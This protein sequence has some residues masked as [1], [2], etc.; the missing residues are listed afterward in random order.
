MQT[1]IR[2]SALVLAAVMSLGVVAGLIALRPPLTQMYY[3]QMA[4]LIAGA[5]L[6]VTL[7]NYVLTA[8]LRRRSASSEHTEEAPTHAAATVDCTPTAASPAYAATEESELPTAPIAQPAGAVVRDEVLHAEEML[9]DGLDELLDM[10]YEAAADDPI[11]AIAAYRRALLRYPD[12]SYMPYLII[13]LSTLYKR[14]GDYDAALALYD[15]ALALSL[16]AK[17]AVMVQEFQRSRK[18]LAVV[19]DMLTALGTPSLPF[20][21][22]SKEII[23]EADRCAEELNI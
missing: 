2:L 13:E 14:L 21:E 3:V 19:S 16:V 23:A 1:Q 15:Q 17:N 20:G 6:V 4:A 11:R 18:A 10:A 12:D 5:G 7:Y 22:V 9:P 8:R